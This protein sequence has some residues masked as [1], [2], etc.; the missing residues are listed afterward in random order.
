MKSKNK[1]LTGTLIFAYVLA[2]LGGCENR[3]FEE[4]LQ[5]SNNLMRH[6]KMVKAQQFE[7][8]LLLEIQS[9]WT[10][11]SRRYLLQNMHDEQINDAVSFQKIKIPVQRIVALSSTQWAP[12]LEVGKSDIILGI[13]E[14]SFVNDRLMKSLLKAGK[15]SEVLKNGQLDFEKIV[16]LQPDIVFYSPDPTGGSDQLERTGLKLLPWPDYLE[17]SPLGRAEWI[18]VLGWLTG[19]EVLTEKLFEDAEKE[20]LALKSLVHDSV[21]RPTIMADKAFNDQWYVPGGKSYMATIFKD[22]GAAY[23]W[24]DNQ[25]TGSVSL[26]IETIISQAAEADFWRIAHATDSPYSYAKLKQEHDIYAAFKA[27]Q[28]HQIIFCNTSKTAYFETS[29]FRPHLVLADFIAILHPDLLPYHKPVYH[30]L[31]KPDSDDN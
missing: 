1:S 31:L 20:Y 16:S 29:Q 27:F 22:A 23:I 30:Q 7:S 12:L 14:A 17:T 2:F 18:R 21:V 28:Q 26:D 24:S 9:P 5:I 4:E 11:N 15:V 13:S 8:G 19:Q 6:A 25:A 3:S 10:E